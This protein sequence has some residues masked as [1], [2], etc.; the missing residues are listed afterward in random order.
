MND[1]KTYI[2]D[3]QSL[4][5][6]E[7]FINL[8][9]KYDVSDIKFVFFTFYG[10]DI[11]EDVKMELREKRDYQQCLR[12]EALYKY[13]YKCVISGNKQKLLLQ[14]AH[15][16]PV[17]ECDTEEEKRDVDNT[18]LLWTD[19][20]IYFDAFLIGINPKTCKVEVKDDYFMEY[21]G[22]TL[23]LNANTKK[24]LE[25]HYEIFKKKN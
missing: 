22:L 11:I 14:V 18:L 13:N 24:Y 23:D 25:Y 12:M 20:H 4:L 16:K 7:I 19:I 9:N 10:V 6:N 3:N 21:D 2:D 8:L 17:S 15:I 1:I 5:K